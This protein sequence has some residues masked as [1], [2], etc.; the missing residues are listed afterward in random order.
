MEECRDR[1]EFGEQRKNITEKNEVEGEGGGGVQYRGIPGQGVKAATQ[2]HV[3]TGQAYAA[4]S[5]QQ[6]RYSSIGTAA[7]AAAAAAARWERR[8]TGNIQYVCREVS[9]YDRS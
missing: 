2:L 3:S 6:Y 4:V 1:Q 9:T 8:S 5:V 7:A